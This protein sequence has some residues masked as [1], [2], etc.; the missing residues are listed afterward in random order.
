MSRTA[1]APH[2]SC[3]FLIVLGLAKS[4]QLFFQTVGLVISFCFLLLGIGWEVGRGGKRLIYMGG[5]L[6]LLFKMLKEVRPHGGLIKWIKP[7]GVTTCSSHGKLHKPKENGETQEE[8][9][10]DQLE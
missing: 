4:P 1:K 8:G 6:W 7:P 5:H 9:S 10:T 3:Q 2:L